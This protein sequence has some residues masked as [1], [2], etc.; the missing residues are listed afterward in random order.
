MS[1]Y[2]LPR[3]YKHKHLNDAGNKARLDIEK[4][5]DKM[6][7]QP[8]GNYST[9]SKNRI[10]HFLRTITFVLGIPIYLKKGDILII[11][12][13]TKYYNTICRIAH[14]CKAYT[15]TLIHDLGC[16]RQKHNSVKKEINRLNKTDALITHNLNYS[17][18]L[19]QNGFIGYNKKKSPI[20]LHAFDFLSKA[21]SPNRKQDW[22]THKITYAGQLAIR[23]N[24]FL[25]DWGNL[26]DEYNINI[27]GKG[28]D[29]SK[30]ASSQKFNI[31]GFMHPEKLI[32][33]SEGDFGLVWDGDSV[34]CCSGNWGEYLKLNAPHKVSL[35][36]RCGL[37]II[38]WRKAAMA[39]FIKENGIGICI[40]SLHEINSIYKHLTKED[41][42][43]MCDNISRISHL[44]SE[45]YYFNRAI[46]EAILCINKSIK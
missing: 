10:L 30:A 22:P 28:F 12:Y 35:Y 19:C 38:I 14:L 25:Y 21:N 31:K 3:D 45:G 6:G 9:I 7:Y 16:F 2:Y 36:I 1:I 39:S 4:T 20:L 24:R 40:D 18:W 43:M 42:F 33:H 41:Y 11:Q 26:A 44:M 27:Y 8:I 32:S 17:N 13:P 46:S 15:I 5:M 29:S 34:D 37:P 23:K